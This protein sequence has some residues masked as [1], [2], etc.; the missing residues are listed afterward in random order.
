MNLNLLIHSYI[1]F[2]DLTVKG[3]GRIESIKRRLYAV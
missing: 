3:Y 1:L 2:I